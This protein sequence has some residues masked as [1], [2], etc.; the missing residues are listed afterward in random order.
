[1]PR[2]V[3]YVEREKGKFRQRFSRFG[4]YQEYHKKVSLR[5][6]RSARA[7]ITLELFNFVQ[8]ISS[9]SWQ[10]IALRRANNFAA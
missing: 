1:M 2:S 3:S 7:R 4:E 5:V 10:G 8:E 6:F 9:F